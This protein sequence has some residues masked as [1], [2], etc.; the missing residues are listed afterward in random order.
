MRCGG[1]IRKWH[2][3]YLRSDPSSDGS[4][5]PSGVFTGGSMGSNY[6]TGCGIRGNQT[7]DEDEAL[8]AEIFGEA[9]ASAYAS[10]AA[11]HE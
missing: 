11:G 7:I 3:K 10:V 4:A 9:F 1:A 6:D 2:L 5:Y 8:H